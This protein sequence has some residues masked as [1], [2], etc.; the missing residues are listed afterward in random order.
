MCMYISMYIPL[1]EYSGYNVNRKLYIVGGIV[2]VQGVYILHTI[3][4]MPSSHGIGIETNA[5]FVNLLN[6]ETE[7]FPGI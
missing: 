2:F 5:A 4:Q 7:L 1:W 6:C 3:V